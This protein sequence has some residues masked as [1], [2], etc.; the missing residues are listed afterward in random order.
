M[1]N[2]VGYVLGENV[3]GRWRVREQ[4][5]SVSE[6][7]RPPPKSGKNGNS[8]YLSPSLLPSLPLRPSPPLAPPVWPAVFVLPAPEGMGWAGGGGRSSTTG[9]D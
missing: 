6:R 7:S 1:N 3:D 5:E 4:G 2:G 8:I 9:K